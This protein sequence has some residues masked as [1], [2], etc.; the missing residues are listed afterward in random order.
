MREA[1][2]PVGPAAAGLEVCGRPR[3][4]VGPVAAGLEVCGRPRAPWGLRRL[5]LRC[6]GG[7]GP[8]WGLWQ[9]DLRCVGGTG[10]L[11]SASERAGLVMTSE[12]GA[13][14]PLSQ[15]EQLSLLVSG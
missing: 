12:H 15:D 9:L 4:P 10:P 2:S 14:P 8:L 5:D 3:A 1:Q 6:A 13:K 11:P 7:P